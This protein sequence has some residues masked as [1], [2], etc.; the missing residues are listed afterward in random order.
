[1]AHALG[2]ADY[3]AFGTTDNRT[4]QIGRLGRV[5]MTFCSFD[6]NS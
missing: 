6:A 5:G 2:R 3:S 1:M 4:P